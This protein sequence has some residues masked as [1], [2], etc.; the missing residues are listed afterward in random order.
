MHALQR[1]LCRIRARSMELMSDC[2]CVSL[3]KTSALELILQAFAVFNRS[4]SVIGCCGDAWN[5]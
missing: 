4:M 3:Q 1:P 2:R 5:P